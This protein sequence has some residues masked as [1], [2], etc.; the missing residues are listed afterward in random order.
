MY[1]KIMKTYLFF[2]IVSSE[3]ISLI[4][5]S[6]FENKSFTFLTLPHPSTGIPSKYCL[7]NV[8]KKI[9]ETVTFSEEYRSWFIGESVK[10]DGNLIMVTPINPL[11]LGNYSSHLLHSVG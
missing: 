10:S 3:H 6:L 4:P 11:L 2:Y 1:H 9:Y 8:K 5:D 7:D